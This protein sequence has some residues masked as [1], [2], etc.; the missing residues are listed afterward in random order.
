MEK[1]LEKIW[2]ERNVPNEKILK[3]GSLPGTGGDAE[4]TGAIID[5]RRR[6]RGSKSW[7][8]GLGLEVPGKGGSKLGGQ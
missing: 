3:V 1:D 7:E 8:E 2:G 5:E 4:G 6:I